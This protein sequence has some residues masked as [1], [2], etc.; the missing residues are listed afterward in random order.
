MT[1]AQRTPWWTNSSRA[2]L[3]GC[4]NSP[5]AERH[6]G[7]NAHAYR[8]HRARS[9]GPAHGRPLGDGWPRR[10]RCLPRPRP[11]R[12]RCCTGR[13]RRR[14][15]A[16]G[17]R[18]LRRGHT[19]RPQ[20]T[21]GDGGDRRH[22][23]GAR[24]GQD[25][26][27]HLHHRPRGGAGAARPGG[28]DRC[29]LS[30]RATLGRYRRR[31][32]GHADP[33]GRRRRGHAGRHGARAGPLRGPGGARGR[34]GHGPGGEAVQPGDLRGANDGHRRGDRHG[35]SVRGRHGETVTRPHARHG[36]LRGGAD[37][38]ACAGCDPREPGVERV[39][40]RVH[41]RSHGQGPRPRHG[42]RR[43]LRRPGA[44]DSDG[45][46]AAHGRRHRR[47]RAEDFSAVAKVVLALSGVQ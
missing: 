9:H 32:E 27:R 28:R 19:L 37:P 29:A 30:G 40:A 46:T 38:A 17:G 42:L 1:C 22:A 13:G 3:S 33:H 24:P 43:A 25:G 31:T 45:A 44:D 18:G 5:P 34:P 10:H 36:R 47:L 2:R 8:I 35:G 41:D 4:P 14:L 6:L 39:A 7:R 20:L 11:D 16:R 26:H 23:A 21:R 12:R 15:A